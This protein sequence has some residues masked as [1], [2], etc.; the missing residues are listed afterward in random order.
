VDDLGEAITALRLLLPPGAKREW[1]CGGMTAR[2]GAQAAFPVGS[3]ASVSSVDVFL[4]EAGVTGAAG[5][6]MR[7][8][9]LGRMGTAGREAA[10]ERAG[11]GL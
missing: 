10:G 8:G 3:G 2:A 1:G 9:G 11:P 4:L 7:V 5:D 6:V